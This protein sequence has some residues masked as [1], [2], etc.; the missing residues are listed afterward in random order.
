MFTP[1]PMI[2]KMSPQLLVTDLDGSIEFF[3]QKLGFTVEFRYEDFYVGLVKDGCSIHLK[4]GYAPVEKNAEKLDIL[5]SVDDIEDVYAD[6]V[7]K[8][9]EIRQRLR[10]M[11]YGKE[12]YV[13]DPDG[14][15]FAFV[16]A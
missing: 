2:K 5:F 9:I 8:T 15:I 4:Q 1:S 12:F 11:P 10:A 14:H 6:L 13:A 7:A 16:E 3:T